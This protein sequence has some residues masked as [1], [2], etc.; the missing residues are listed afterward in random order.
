MST[1][2]ISHQEQVATLLPE[3]GLRLLDARL[4]NVHRLGEISNE[5]VIFVGRFDTSAVGRPK[6]GDY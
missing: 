1:H 5:E 4:P 3:P 6:A 2:P